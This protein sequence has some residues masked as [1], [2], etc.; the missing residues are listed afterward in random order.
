[1]TDGPVFHRTAMRPKQWEVECPVCGISVDVPEVEDDDAGVWHAA[2]EHCVIECECGA[3][4][5]PFGAR[6]S[7]TSDPPWSARNG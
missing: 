6:V 3:A 4:I 1:M 2:N 7:E 5:E